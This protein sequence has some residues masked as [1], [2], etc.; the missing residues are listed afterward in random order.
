M[1]F[2]K[3][4]MKN[5]YKEKNKKMLWQKTCQKCVSIVCMLTEER[6]IS[7]AHALEGEGDLPPGSNAGPGSGV[8]VW[9]GVGKTTPLY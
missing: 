3:Q 6:W 7:E 4:Y 9:A 8:G 1:H 5:S 2:K